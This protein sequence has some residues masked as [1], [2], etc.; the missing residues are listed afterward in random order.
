MRPGWVGVC[1]SF[2]TLMLL[3]VMMRRP[4]LSPKGTS[5]QSTSQRKTLEHGV[6]KGWRREIAEGFVYPFK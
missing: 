1:L 5:G 6:S 3:G 4:H 2:R